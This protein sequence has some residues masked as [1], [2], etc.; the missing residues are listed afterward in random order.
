MAKIAPATVAALAAAALVEELVFRVALKALL[1][2]VLARRLVPVRALVGSWIL[3]AL[4]FTVLPG[5]L[6]Q[7]A[8]WWV[9]TAFALLESV[10]LYYN[11]DL[12]LVVLVHLG[13]NLA[14]FAALPNTVERLAVATLLVLAVLAGRAAAG[15]DTT[16]DNDAVSETALHLVQPH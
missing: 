6:E 7:S 16:S 11:R 9:F 10:L 13:V 4:A 3:S 2:S 14:S 15:D 8:P 1:E 5:H 12:V